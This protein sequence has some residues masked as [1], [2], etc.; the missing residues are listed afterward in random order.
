MLGIATTEVPKE[1]T[2]VNGDQASKYRTVT[3]WTA[4]FK[5]SVVLLKLIFILFD[6][7]CMKSSIIFCD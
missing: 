1:I 2:V 6:L 4:L 5:E 3:K 7:L